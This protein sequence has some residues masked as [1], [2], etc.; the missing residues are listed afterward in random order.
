MGKP[1]PERNGSN[2]P[3]LPQHLADLRRSGLSDQQI[4][5]CRFHSLQAPA[6]VQKALRW[7]RYD[8]ALGDCLCIPFTDADG[9]PVDYRRLKPD[10]PRQSKDG[11]PVKYESPKGSSNLPYFPPG[12]L[13]ALRAPSAALVITEGEKKAAKSDQEGFP[14]I[15]LMGVY[16]WQ[17]RRLRDEHGRGKGDRELIEALAR[18]P[19]QDRPVFLCFDSD[20]ATNPNVRWAEWHLAAALAHRGALVRVVRLPAGD[21]GPDGTPAKGGLDDYLVAHGSDTFRE[22]LAAAVEPTPPAKAGRDRPS[23]TITVEEHIVNAQAVAA[24]AGDDAI[25]QRGGML[26]HVVRDIS[27]AAKGIRRPFAPRIETLPPPLLR[28]RL[29]ANAQWLTVQE[30]K[31]G[32][33]EKPA[34]PPAWCVAA[35]HA[36]ANWPGIRHL[37]AVVDY[38]V[39]RPDGTILSRPGYDPETGLLLEPGAMFPAIPD[40]PSKAE[41]L[42]ARDRLLDVVSDFPFEADMHCAA[43]LAGLLTPFA[44]FAFPGPAPLFLVDSNVRGAGKGL[45]VNV[46]SRIVTGEPL[47]IATYTSDEDELRKR[48]TSLVLAGD[49]LVLFDNLEGKFGNAV[50]D[51]ALTGTAWKD[52]LLGVNRMAEAPLFM[53]WY[54]TG[55]NVA[56]AADTARRVCHIRLESPEEHPE[57]RQGFRH[58]DLLVWVGANRPALLTAALTI[59]RAYCVAGRPGL[60]L[61]A[62]GSFEGW[63]ALVRAAVVWV[64]LPDPGETRLFLQRQAD[65]AA[66]AMD[67]L[68]TCWER[69][70][71]D[72]RG[73]TAA[74]VIEL[75]KNPQANP[76]DGYADLRDAL[77]ALLGKPEP[78]ALGNKL[79]SYCRRVFGGRFVDRAGSRQRAARWAVFP[80]GE[81]SCRLKQSHQTHQTHPLWSECGES[82]ECVSAGYASGAKAADAGGHGDAWE[83]NGQ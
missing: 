14:C 28:E 65:V 50:L 71:P 32:E 1:P 46:Q 3:L 43:W 11:K 37:E 33:V 78:R 18:I 72:K 56:I 74:E 80:V 10:R 81:F 75:Y 44:R 76:P 30:T 35:V 66:E 68:L 48:I 9:K 26:V 4:A 79:R 41:A 21:P 67:V 77:E 31:H 73:L 82:G 54:A 6:S 60:G 16:G 59:L 38:P 5:A 61:S 40:R 64:G 19:W 34:R 17:K 52:R 20:A 29:A 39:L 53:T 22:L 42:A 69:L 45:L 36:R 57:E 15:G 2:G 55:N 58:P 25:Y 24:L 23:I 51:A 13:A 49:R 47:T 63:S 70:D 7:K 62:W 83:G 8:G 27:P 12:T